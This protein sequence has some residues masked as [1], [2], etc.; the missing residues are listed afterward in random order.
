[1]AYKMTHP[2]SDQT[3][4]VH[5]DQVAN[6]E[7]QGWVTAPNAKKPSTEDDEK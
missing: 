2:D 5:A 3:I 1:M 7:S 6:Y 4:E